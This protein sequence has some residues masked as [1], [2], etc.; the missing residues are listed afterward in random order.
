MQNFKYSNLSYQLT[1]DLS[2]YTCGIEQCSPGHAYGPTVRR[3]YMFY[4]ILNGKGT[5]WFNNDIY[6]L[7]SKE[8]F[9][10]IPNTLIRFSASE[11]EPWQYLWIGLTGNQVAN[12]IQNISINRANPIFSFNIG[13]EIYKLAEEIIIDY[14]GCPINNL[15]VTT[16]LYNL[17]DNFSK[18]YPCLNKNN[19]RI[20]N[21]DILESAIFII[22]NNYYDTQLS[23][24]NIAA[25]LHINRSH[26]YKLFK[27]GLNESPQQ[28]LIRYRIDRA[29]DLIENEDFPFN[30]IATSVGYKDPLSFSREFKHTLG[31]SPSEYRRVYKKNSE[32]AISLS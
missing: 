15:K 9:L 30:V 4:F 11:N 21:Q 12:Y 14:Q 8:G 20:N 13:D 19:L 5:Y 6:H 28:Y 7:H 2:C 16:N 29:K 10:I 25:Q 31:I 18:S 23:I 17:L 26:L 32:F 22:N 27:A 24:N 3:G 1:R